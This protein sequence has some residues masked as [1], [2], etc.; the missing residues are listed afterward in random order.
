MNKQRFFTVFAGI[1]VSL[2]L[3]STASGGQCDLVNKSAG[4]SLLKVAGSK[5][6][7]L[8]NG[9]WMPIQDCSGLVVVAGGPVQVRGIVGG[10][11]RK[12]LCE[13]DKPC[14][15]PAGSRSFVVSSTSS[16]TLVE[17][18]HRMDETVTRKIG[19]PVGEVYSI[20]AAAQFQFQDLPEAPTAFALFAHG[21]PAPVYTTKVA[22]NK[23]SIPRKQL[24]RGEKYSWEVYGPRGRSQI[25][26]S[27]GFDLMGAKNAA[28]VTKEISTLNE[29]SGRSVAERLL[30]EIAVFYSYDLSYETE[31]L[32]QT[33]AGLN[34]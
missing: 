28:A 6:V 16:Y 15:L 2:L 22:G 13:V 9:A 5:Q 32:R 4:E 18:G 26:A 14:E 10:A 27:G 31:M 8:A 12:T 19:V 33:L 30:D 11:P 3:V 7:R 23:V 25:L 21:K 24:K 17:G 34:Q 1:A 29:N 20:D